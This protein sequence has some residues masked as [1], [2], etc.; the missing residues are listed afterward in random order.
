MTLHSKIELAIYALVEAGL[1]PVEI[2]KKLGM[3]LHRIR[4]LLDMDYLNE[5]REKLKKQ[6]WHNR[7]AARQRRATEKARKQDFETSRKQDRI[8]GRIPLETGVSASGIRFKKQPIAD[9]FVSLPVLSF[10]EREKR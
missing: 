7:Q 3:D 1:S 2:S 6:A 4:L 10:E 8:A 9:G 5:H